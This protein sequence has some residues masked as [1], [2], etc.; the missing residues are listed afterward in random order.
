MHSKG[1]VKAVLEDQRTL[2]DLI[3][4]AQGGDRAAFDALASHYRDRLESGISRRLG[5]YLRH[6]VE[7]EDVAQETLLKAFQSLGSFE[8][9][10]RDSFLKW[11]KGIADNLLLYWAREYR[12]MDQMP[13]LQDASHHDTSPSKRLRREE[14][15]ER[16][17]AALSRLG[18]DQREVILLA[19]VEGI[20]T[21]E[22]AKRLDRS[23]AAVRQILWR[24]L[25]KMQASFGDTES[26]SLP[27]NA[28]LKNTHEDSKSPP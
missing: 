18:E 11:L 14:R 13:L 3:R 21:Q 24:A 1:G 6:K 27:R 20:P 16:L 4:R 12:R 15:F 28:L 9:R 26:L 22:I 19:R 8:E 7:V 10:G 2:K 17:Q 25:Q 5:G 23:P